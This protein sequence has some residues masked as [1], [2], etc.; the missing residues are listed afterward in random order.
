MAVR[1]LLRVYCCIGCPSSSWSSRGSGKLKKSRLGPTPSPFT[2]SSLLLSF[3]GST[4]WDTSVPS[5]A[6]FF[7]FATPLFGP[8]PLNESRFM[9]P[10]LTVNLRVA[11][12]DL[13]TEFSAEAGSS[14]P[15]PVEVMMEGSRARPDHPEALARLARFGLAVRRGAL[16]RPIQGWNSMSRE[17]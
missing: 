16:I 11:H 3:G 8:L 12:L 14:A 1:I 6:L 9:A 7:S 15:P 10:L 13:C 17:S 5:D 2:S 4:G